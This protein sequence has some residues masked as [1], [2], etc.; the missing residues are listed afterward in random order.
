MTQT[1]DSKKV[2]FFTDNETNEKHTNSRTHC[3]KSVKYSNASV[4][5]KGMCFNDEFGL[6]LF[7]QTSN[8]LSATLY[9]LAI[10]PKIQQKLRENLL[11]NPKT[12]YLTACIKESMRLLPVAG[13]NVRE[14]TKDYELMG[15][16]IPKGV[17]KK[18]KVKLI[19]I[20]TINKQ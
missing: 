1:F 11:S 5:D 2:K 6:F 3:Q 13:L 20:F 7:F 19:V 9:L 18:L 12:P 15:Y 14:T 10:N 4:T 16:N 8:T 17:N